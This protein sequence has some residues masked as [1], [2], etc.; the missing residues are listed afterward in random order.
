M[1]EWMNWQLAQGVHSEVTG[2]G[3]SPTVILSAGEA[4]IEK[5]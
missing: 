4:V 5:N 1:D 3:A 2:T